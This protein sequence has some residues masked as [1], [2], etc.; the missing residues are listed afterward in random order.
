MV[1]ATSPMA[2]AAAS[3][4]G[5]LVRWW[6][7]WLRVVGMSASLEL[8]AVALDVSGCLAVVT[9]GRLIARIRMRGA[10]GDMVAAVGAP[11]VADPAALLARVVRGCGHPAVGG[12]RPRCDLVDAD[13]HGFAGG[14]R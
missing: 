12:G 13:A 11:V 14:L 3:S 5:V 1:G 8:G 2:S 10:G 9:C 4:S 7:T 6:L